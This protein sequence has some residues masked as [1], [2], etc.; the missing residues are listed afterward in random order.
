MAQAKPIQ[1][2][3]LAPIE[4]NSVTN[5][6]VATASGNP[7]E[8]EEEDDIFSKRRMTLNIPSNCS[9]DFANLIVSNNWLYCLLT[10]QGRYN[11]LRFF[12][13]R[14]IPPGRKSAPLP[15]GTRLLFTHTRTN[16]PYVP[17]FVCRTVIGKISKWL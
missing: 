4:G 11:L 17:P 6:Y 1:P 7:F 12:L 13:P 5:K 2:K 3:F 15:N 14:A 16:I 9:G 8:V 10:S